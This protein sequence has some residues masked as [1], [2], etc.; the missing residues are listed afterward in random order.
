[1]IEVTKMLSKDEAIPILIKMVADLVNRVT[2]L[3]TKSETNMKQIANLHPS[4]KKI[5]VNCL[6][7]FTEHGAVVKECE[8]CGNWHWQKEN[9]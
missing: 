8:F 6:N 3:E 4:L 9:E 1:M 5:K 7:D 2:L